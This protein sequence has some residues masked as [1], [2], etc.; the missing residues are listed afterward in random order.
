MRREKFRLKFPGVYVLTHLSTGN[1]YIGSSNDIAGRLSEHSW[2]LGRGI[3]ESDRLQELFNLDRDVEVTLVIPTKTVE[4]AR[5]QEEEMLLEQRES[6]LL[7]N[8]IF[9]AN[10]LYQSGEANPMF[11]RPVS[12]TTRKKL[13]VANK[14]RKFHTDESKAR[15]AASKLGKPLSAEHIA[16]LRLKAKPVSIKGVKYNSAVEAAEALGISQ[17]TV[18][19]YAVSKKPQHADWFYLPV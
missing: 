17:Y 13:S 7:V 6:P 5:Q 15:I 14:G 3:H 18:R 19:V 11:G 16:K 9:Q 2:K 4:Q 8:R 12:E 10:V 1:F